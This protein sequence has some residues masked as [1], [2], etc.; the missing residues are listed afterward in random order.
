MSLNDGAIVEVV[1]VVVE[2]V[3]EVVVEVVLA[4]LNNS[5]FVE[6]VLVVVSANRRC[7]SAILLK[8]TRSLRS[9]PKIWDNYSKNIETYIAHAKNKLLLLLAQF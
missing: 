8:M 4:I 5:S 6:A 1:E 2:D 9:S 7:K 3:V